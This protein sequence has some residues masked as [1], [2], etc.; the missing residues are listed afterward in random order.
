MKKRTHISILIFVKFRVK[1]LREKRK[2]RVSGNTRGKRRKFVLNQYTII[3]TY[4]ALPYFACVSCS[5][6]M[7]SLPYPIKTCLNNRGQTI[8]LHFPIYYYK[9]NG[10]EGQIMLIK[11]YKKMI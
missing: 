8:F 4:I 10:R 2:P 9:I 5:P 7:A 11:R 6:L 1:Y 3:I